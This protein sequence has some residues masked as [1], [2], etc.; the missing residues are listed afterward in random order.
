MPLALANS[1][2]LTAIDAYAEVVSAEATSK[3]VYF[4]GDDDTMAWGFDVDGGNAKKGSHDRDPREGVIDIRE[5]DVPYYLRVA[6]DNGM[7]SLLS[8]ECL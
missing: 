6:I 5:F 2:K 3:N 1:A 4:D 7:S 8:T